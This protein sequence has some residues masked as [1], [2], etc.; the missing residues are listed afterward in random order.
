M[1]F[2]EGDDEPAYRRPPDP[3]DRIW[4]HPSEVGPSP[5]NQSPSG[6]T[7]LRPRPQGPTYRTLWF[8]AVAS[9]VGASVLTVTVVLA[10]GALDGAST[11]GGATA[12]SV[13]EPTRTVAGPGADLEPVAAV[14]ERLRPS[15][16]QLQ[17]RR[18]IDGTTGSGVLFRADGHVLTNAHVL[19]GAVTVKALLAD[20]RAVPATVVGVDPDSDIGVVKLEG[21]PFVAAE[22]DTSGTLE[23]G[24][25]AVAIGSPLGLAGGPS[26][27]A[28][29]VSALHRT[30]RTEA[31]HAF[32]GMIQTDAPIS[33]GSSGGAL[34]DLDGR[35]IGITTAVS[36]AGAG[37]ESPGFATPARLAGA[38]AGQ[39]IGTGTVRSVWLG[40]E[41]NDLDGTTAHAL[42][43]GGGAVVNLVKDGSPAAQAGLTA[44]DVIVA[45]EGEAVT[46]MGMLVVA[47]RMLEPGD[48]ATVEI[49]RDGERH[50]MDVVLVERPPAPE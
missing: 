41:G 20:G 6:P 33:P 17:V 27:T 50:T 22:L 25:Q 32:Y 34:A 3:D 49:R 16:V 15:I 36:V 14:A 43:L 4:R 47:L 1:E 37:S 24:Q 35:V 7:R 45:V 11:T 26:V 12:A 46:S 5:A 30:V 48:T 19:E 42:G 21:G 31:G 23:V 9:A 18:E 44:R 13:I 39:L 10:V 40:I 38:I 29:V 28:G 8:V 2:V